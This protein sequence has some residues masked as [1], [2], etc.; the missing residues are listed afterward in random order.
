MILVA[1]MES[2]PPE[3]KE[4]ARLIWVAIG[5]PE[6]KR[7]RIILYCQKITRKK[8]PIKN[9][10]TLNLAVLRYNAAS[11]NESIDDP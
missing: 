9:G 5:Q 7:A 11:S 2:S 6:L 10:R 1:S 4:T 3:I 8:I